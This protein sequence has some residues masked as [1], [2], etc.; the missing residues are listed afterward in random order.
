MAY[1]TI[2]MSAKDAGTIQVKSFSFYTNC[3]L[4]E[5]Y[6]VKDF[7]EFNPTFTDVK[8]VSFSETKPPLASSIL[9]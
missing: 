2:T 8:V 4:S 1:F 3:L 5:D 9:D 7:K 6:F